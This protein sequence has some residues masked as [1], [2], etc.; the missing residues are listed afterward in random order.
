MKNNLLESQS[1]LNFTTLIYN[2]RLVKMIVT[3]EQ[4]PVYDKHYVMDDKVK[5]PL[6][7]VKI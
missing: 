3:S 2:F 5:L 7:I 4:L 1:I 6:W